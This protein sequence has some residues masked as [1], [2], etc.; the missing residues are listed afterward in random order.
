MKKYG[1]AKVEIIDEV[2]EKNRYYVKLM[3]ANG[4]RSGTYGVPRENVTD[5]HDETDWGEV[6]KGTPVAVWN[7]LGVENAEMKFLAGWIGNTMTACNTKKDAIREYYPK[8]Y[9]HAMLLTEW[10]KK[11]FPIYLS[12]L[13]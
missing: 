4:F 1:R 3:M 9:Q 5:I 2:E 7:I 12:F 11:H 13:D 6:E 8:Y 10:M